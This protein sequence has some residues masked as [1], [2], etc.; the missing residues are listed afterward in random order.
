[1]NNFYYQFVILSDNYN[2]F[3]IEWIG[4]LSSIFIK[5]H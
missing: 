1:M 4:M 2:T 5:Y 3:Q